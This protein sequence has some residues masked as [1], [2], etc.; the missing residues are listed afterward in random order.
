MRYLESRLR[1]AEVVLAHYEGDVPFPLHLKAFFR[2]NKRFGSRD[3]RELAEICYRFFRLG[4]ALPDL[5]LR[6]RIE[7]AMLINPADGSYDTL[8]E[9][10]PDF[11]PEDILPVQDL[12]STGLEG[13]S[14]LRSHLRQ[15]D[16]FIRIRPGRR[17]EVIETLQSSGIPC[18]DI[19]ESALAFDN[20]TS[21]EALGRPDDAYVVQDLSSQ[22][23]AEFMPPADMLP[24]GPKVRDVCAGSGGKSI[25]AWD[26]YPGARI[27]ASDLRPS[28]LANLE[29]RFRS[30]G[31]TGYRAAVEDVTVTRNRKKANGTYDLVIV[32]APCTGSGTWART[33]W[34]IVLFDPASVVDFA[35]RQRAIAAASVP[36]V[37]PGGFMLYITCSAF[38]AENEEVATFIETECGMR[39]VR[40]GLLQGHSEGADTMY[41]ALFTSP[42][43]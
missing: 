35:A 40:S 39:A 17:R 19:S 36:L 37:R 38:A 29:A 16:L 42:A 8:T 13:P 34:D 27:D 2:D 10:H 30:A 28:I 20:G 41:A 25:L 23:T 22:R 6:P 12:F 21:L 1:T 7:A 32:D 15:P 14:F 9:R 24:D 4:H 5:D 31:L 3:R 26:R 43:G 18:R 11:R 33:P